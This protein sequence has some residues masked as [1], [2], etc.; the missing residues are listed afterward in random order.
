MMRPYDTRNT[1]HC[2]FSISAF[3]TDTPF[4]TSQ[5]MEGVQ[6]VSLTLGH[7]E[8]VPVG[9]P[10]YNEAS[11]IIGCVVLSSNVVVQR[12]DEYR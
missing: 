6:E 5:G 1:N 10:L 12:L 3:S 4:L 2:R 11:A 9:C 8:P 7:D